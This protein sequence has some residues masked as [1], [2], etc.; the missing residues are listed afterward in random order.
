M[1]FWREERYYFI[2]QKMRTPTSYSEFYLAGTKYGQRILCVSDSQVDLV[3][4][5]LREF[6]YL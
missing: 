2:L 6:F 3:N 4:A 5:E 1:W